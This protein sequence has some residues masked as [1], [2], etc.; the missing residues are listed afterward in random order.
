MGVDYLSTGPT[1]VYIQHFSNN[2]LT[3][4]LPM[5]ITTGGIRRRTEHLWKPAPSDGAGE[6]NVEATYQGTSFV[7]SF[8]LSVHDISIVERAKLPLPNFSLVPGFIP[9]GAIGAF[10]R[11]QKNYFRL[12][13]WL[14]YASAQGAEEF[15][16]MPMTRLGSFDEINGIE[17]KR[18]NMTWIGHT[19]M[20]YCA[21]GNGSFYNFDGTGWPG[22]ISCPT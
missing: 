18:I 1:H 13:C 15:L 22:A 20:Q 5:G 7:L 14:P 3:S 10:L 9:S 12:L 8:T 4:V 2:V 19:L 16:N 17:E 11:K 21:G 6:Q